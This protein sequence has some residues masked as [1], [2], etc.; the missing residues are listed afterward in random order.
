MRPKKLYLS[1]AGF[2]IEL[3]LHPTDYKQSEK[4]FLMQL[5]KVY[6]GFLIDYPKTDIDFTIHIIKNDHAELLK[7]KNKNY[8]EYYKIIKKNANSL[9]T[10]YSISFEQ[11][12]DLLRFV[13]FRLLRASGFYMHG[14]GVIFKKKA[15]LFIGASGE[16]KSTIITLLKDYCKPF[17]DDIFIVRKIKNEF[18]CFQSHSLDKQIW[19]KKENKGYIINKVFFIH[20]S[21]KTYIKMISQE[22]AMKLLINNLIPSYDTIKYNI[23]T[24][25]DFLKFH[26]ER[27]YLL[28][29]KK[30]RQQ[31]LDIILNS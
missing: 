17:A 11:F 26:Y 15:I 10:F 31:I 1:I 22:K 23:P 2:N 29:F 8:I 28:M 19:I 24:L 12:T 25:F 9:I 30:N 20:K 7:Y 27:S 4:L 18:L 14:A 5:F 3:L 16:G 6:R 13:L 21:N